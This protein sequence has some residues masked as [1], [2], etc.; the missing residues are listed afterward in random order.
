MAGIEEV[1]WRPSSFDAL[2]LPPR[3]K[4]MIMA[5]A[6]ARTGDFDLLSVDDLVA[7]KGQGL[8]FLLQ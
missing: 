8:N 1:V 6:E 2:I 4:D 5:L 7:G 3:I